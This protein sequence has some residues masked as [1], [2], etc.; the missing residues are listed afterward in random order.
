MTPEL[1]NIIAGRLAIL[2]QVLQE[3]LR[4]L[5][6]LRQEVAALGQKHKLTQPQTP[7]L[8]NE[9]VLTL[10]AFAP[11]PDLPENLSRGLWIQKDTTLLIV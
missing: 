9:V 5:A 2:P 10:L 3:K 11:Y 1:N 8:E 6:A 7:T 4:D